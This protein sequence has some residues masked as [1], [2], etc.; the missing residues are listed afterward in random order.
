MLGLCFGISNKSAHEYKNYITPF[1]KQTLAA[2]D[3]LAHR[4][5]E[6][7]AAF[8]Q[9]FEGVTDICI[10]GYEL[11]I[12]RNQDKKVQKDHHSGKK[13]EIP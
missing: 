1:L 12:E 10:D 4:I 11:P 8:D 2:H 5:F 6:D 9:A 7:Q 13:K 3:A